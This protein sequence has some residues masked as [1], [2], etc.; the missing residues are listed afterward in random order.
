M[1]LSFYQET[2][3]FPDCWVAQKYHVTSAHFTA[4]G[5]VN[6]QRWDGLILNAKCTED[7]HPGQHEAGL[8]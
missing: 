7:S 1:R 6:G 4:I 2:R 3:R 8:G 5:A